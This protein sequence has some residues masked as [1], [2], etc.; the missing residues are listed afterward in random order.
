MLVF[1]SP[2]TNVFKLPDLVKWWPAYRKRLVLMINP[3]DVQLM[4]RKA[5]KLEMNV[6]SRLWYRP[7]SYNRQYYRM[8]FHLISHWC[9]RKCHSKM[10]PNNLI[11]PDS[12]NDHG[13][14]KDFPL[15]CLLSI[16]S[17]INSHWLGHS[18]AFS[19]IVR[20]LQM[21]PFRWLAFLSWEYIC[22]Y[23]I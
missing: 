3:S 10:M 13:I 15:K 11:Y 9:Q 6:K 22:R 20:P 5:Y 4:M 19:L 18:L 16:D 21:I 2:N 8:N 7:V 14:L 23:C 17:L 1:W 12:Y